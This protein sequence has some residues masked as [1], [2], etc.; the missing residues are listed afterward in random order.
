MNFDSLGDRMKGQYERRAQ[1]WLPRRTF[2]IV[3]LDGKAFHTYTRGLE[4]PYDLRLMMDMGYTAAF[5]CQEVQGAV[6]A[7]TQSDEISLLL[8]DYASPG[9]QAWFDGNVQK[10][11]SIS[12]SACTAKFN[13]LRPGKLA[14][15]DSR[16]FVIPDPV[17]VVNYFVWRQRDAIRN[18]ILMLGQAHFSHKQLQGL[19]TNQIQELLWQEKQ[20]NWSEEVTQFKRGQLTQRRGSHGDD[21]V[22][23]SSWITEAAPD[24]NFTEEALESWGLAHLKD[25]LP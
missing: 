11:V 20:I 21:G 2:T 3:R 9:T 12:A 8:T 18:S 24:L 6:L 15:F 23:R 22:M 17:E 16:A 14:M 7:Y 4:R 19:N 13:A 1:S 5:L 10:I 25:G